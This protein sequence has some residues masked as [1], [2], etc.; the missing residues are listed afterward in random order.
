MSS[1]N[2]KGSKWYKSGKIQCWDYIISQNM[3]FLEGNVVK[4]ITRYKTKNG[5]ADLE[6]AKH[7]IEKLIE[8]YKKK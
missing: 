4:Y 5:L 2:T 7:Y 1:V 3:G 8:V 6:K